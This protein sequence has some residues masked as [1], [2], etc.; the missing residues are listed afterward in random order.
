MTVRDQV[1]YL[2]SHIL[3]LPYETRVEADRIVQR[4]KEAQRLSQWQQVKLDRY[5][6]EIIETLRRNHRR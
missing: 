4:W 2:K 1:A 6:D 5:I 3:T